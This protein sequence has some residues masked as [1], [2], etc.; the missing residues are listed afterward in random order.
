MPIGYYQSHQTH[1]RC[2]R[3]LF[4]VPPK[5]ALPTR[6][7]M[8][9]RFFLPLAAFS[10]ALVSPALLPAQQPDP[11]HTASRQELSIIKVLLAQ[12]NAWNKGDI[13]RYVNGFKDS[14]DTLFI[15]H[16]IFL[17][18]SDLLHVYMSD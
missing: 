8:P 10:L 2:M 17:G 6:P 9:L 18:F 1:A 12:E 3:Q 15:S 16:P 11:L 4:T 14:P 5:S 13:A 7:P